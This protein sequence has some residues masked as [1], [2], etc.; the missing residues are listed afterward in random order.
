MAKIQAG[1]RRLFDWAASLSTIWKFILIALACFVIFALSKGPP[2]GQNHFVYLAEAFLHG[3]ISL[4]GAGTALAEIVPY[5]GNYYVVYPPMPAVLLLPFVAVFGTSFDQSLLSIMLASVCVSLT[6]L[7]LRATGVRGSKVLWLAVLFGFGTCFW[8]TAAVGSSWYIEHVV[9]V[10]FLTSAIILALYKKNGFWV[11]L[12]LG[13]ATL[14][15]FP[16]VLSFPFFLL[17][18]YEQNV[19]WKVRL[20]KAG[21]FLLGLAI[22]VGFNA[23]Y[24]FARYGTPFDIGYY[25]IPGISQDQFFQQGIF[26]I[27]YIPRHIYA[28]LFQGPILVDSIPLFQTQLDGTRLVLHHTRIHLHLQRKMGQTKQ[29]RRHSGAVHSANPDYA[30]QRRLNPVRLPLQPRLHTLPDAADRQRNAGKPW[31]IRESPHNPEHFG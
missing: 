4:S 12:M 9:A 1:T 5:H 30:W 14:A 19:T 6:W 8:F 22:P 21:Y 11:G 28:I 3:K 23:A 2:P 10:L 18:T 16:V 29:I 20:I 27:A 24:D 26:N 17:L 31:Q 13:L 15:R 25:L 7:M